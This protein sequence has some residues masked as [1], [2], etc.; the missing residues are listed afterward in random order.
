ML[1]KKAKYALRALVVMEQGHER[2]L[3]ARREGDRD[4]SDTAAVERKLQ[5]ARRKLGR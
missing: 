4:D 2:A 3:R 5:D 1:T